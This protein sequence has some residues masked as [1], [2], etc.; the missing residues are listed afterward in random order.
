MVYLAGTVYSNEGEAKSFLFRNETTKTIRGLLFFARSK[1]T[2]L[3]IITIVVS[4]DEG[5]AVV[6]QVQ[7]VVIAIV[8]VGW[9]I[10]FVVHRRL[11]QWRHFLIA[12]A[13]S[14]RGL[15]RPGTTS[16]M[17]AVFESVCAVYFDCFHFIRVFISHYWLK[18][19]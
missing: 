8:R 18:K 6:T 4:G 7:F 10:D 16:F 9:V 5:I 2:I 17:I 11:I 13:V 1:S 14:G 12:G 15:R 3:L 19:K